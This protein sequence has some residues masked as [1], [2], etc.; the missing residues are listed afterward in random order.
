MKGK[1]L[2]NRIPFGTQP[3]WVRRCSGSLPRFD[4]QPPL[5]LFA[6]GAGDAEVGAGL[7]LDF[8]VAAAAAEEDFDA[9]DADDG[10]AVDA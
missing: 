6:A 10:G 2:R 4:P 7:E 3:E 9:V 8:V 5:Q 1:K